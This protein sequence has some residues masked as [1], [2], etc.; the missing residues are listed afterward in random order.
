MY[1]E[2]KLDSGRTLLVTVKEDGDCITLSQQFSINGKLA[3]K[4]CTVTCHSTGKS[5]SWTCSDSQDCFGDCSDPNNPKGR[6]T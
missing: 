4:T 6:C 5:Y 3:T 1:Q 2:F